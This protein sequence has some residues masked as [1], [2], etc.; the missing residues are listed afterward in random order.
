VHESLHWHARTSD[1]SALRGRRR[2]V[3]MV[4]AHRGCS[5]RDPQ[6]VV[7]ATD[8]NDLEVTQTTYGCDEPERGCGS[9]TTP[10]RTTHSTVVAAVESGNR[11]AEQ[12][13]RVEGDGEEGQCRTHT[14]PHVNAHT[15]MHAH[16]H[17]PRCI[18]DA[19]PTFAGCSLE[20][21]S[22]PHILFILSSTL[23]RLRS[24]AVIVTWFGSGATA[25]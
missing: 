13:P 6:T 3:L 8:D 25:V 10:C 14:R 18:A 12:R 4:Q 20:W 17:A 24:S 22:L 9:R 1:T 7:V 5:T 19:L 15:H 21:A 23:S 2:T 11:P 16:T